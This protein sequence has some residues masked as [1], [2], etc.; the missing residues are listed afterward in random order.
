MHRP[1]RRPADI[2]HSG[3]FFATGGG[4]VFHTCDPHGAVW[5]TLA[6]LKLRNWVPIYLVPA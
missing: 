4:R 5:D 1:F 3:V 2:E 6:E